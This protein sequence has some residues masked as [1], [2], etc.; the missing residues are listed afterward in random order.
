MFSN[1]R[2]KGYER[3]MNEHHLPI[4]KEN[5]ISV[6]KATDLD[7]ILPPILNHN[8]NITA[9]FTMSDELLAKSLYQVNRLGL[10]IPKDISIMSISDGIYP[11]LS[12]P[13][14]THIKDSG[15]KMGKNAAKLLI[16][17]I[18]FF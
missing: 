15:N 18:F 13:Q 12:H 1:E 7:I 6:E 8:K 14:I 4:L 3:A 10:S 11:Y 16:Q 9:I 2:I 17:L 5:I